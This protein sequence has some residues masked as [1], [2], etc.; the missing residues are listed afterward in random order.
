MH[1]ITI[2]R[3]YLGLTQQALAKNAGITQCDL[4]EIETKPPYGQIDKYRRL[5]QVLD[6]PIHA[7]VTNDCRQI[8]MCFFEKHPHQPYTVA[9]EHKRA[10]MGRGGEELA[11]QM[12]QKRLEK[13]WPVLAQLVLPYFKLRTKSRGY[14]ILSFDENGKPFLI[15]VKTTANTAQTDFN[16]TVNEYETAI[17]QTKLGVPY[18]IYRYSGWGSEKLQLDIVDFAELQSGKRIEP[19]DYVCSMKLVEQEQSGIA[20]W[21]QKRGIN[22]AELARQMEIM[23][24]HLCLYEKGARKCSVKT[25]LK[26]SEILEVSIDE[27]L[28]T[29][30]V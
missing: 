15:E 17:R 30:P 13:K 12:E 16:L 22:Q 18:R 8:P 28:K 21:R 9:A 3:D 24:Q 7:I 19:S 23:P 20:Y 1:I 14:D 27:L 26:I 29:Y 5:S 25:Y 2:L 4:C 6:V 11:L 10:H